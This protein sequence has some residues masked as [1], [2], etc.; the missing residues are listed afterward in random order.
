MELEEILTQG[1]EELGLPHGERVLAGFRSYYRLLEEGGSQMNPPAITGEAG[2]ARLHFLDC[3]AILRQADFRGKRVLDVGSGAGF[4]GL[5]LKIL[6]P[7]LDLTLLDSLQKRV[8]FQ[9]EVCRALDFTDVRCLHLRAEEAPADMREGYD[10]AV[11]RAVARL[12]VLSELCIP[13]VRRDGLFLAMKGPA[14]REE[15]EESLPAFEKL[16]AGEPELI[17]YT[18][19]GLGAERALVRSVKRRAT[20]PQFP[21][22][23]AQIRKKPL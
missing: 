20:P 4:P 9:Q 5:V 2:V 11:S 12:N 1:L 8:A 13:F 7:D 18:V 15:L 14:A 10:I 22:R 6:L 3:A 17:S 21:R 23:F 19:P 16:G